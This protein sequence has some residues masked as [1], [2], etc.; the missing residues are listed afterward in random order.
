VSADIGLKT[1]TAR[2]VA[3][4]ALFAILGPPIGFLA[5]L[6]MPMVFAFGEVFGSG[7][8]S[9]VLSSLWSLAKTGVRDSYYIG[10]QQALLVGAIAAAYAW[11]TARLPYWVALVASLASVILFWLLPFGRGG[12]LFPVLHIFSALVVCW[13]AR[14]LIWK[15]AAT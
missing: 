11:K 12:F 6:L 13:I 9:A 4:V 1:K 3:T 15:P 10:G 5:L 2:T 7:N 14:R 8:I